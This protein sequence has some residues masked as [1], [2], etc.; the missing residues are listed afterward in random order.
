MADKSQESQ[1]CQSCGYPAQNGHSKTCPTRSDESEKARN[2][3]YELFVNFLVKHG[4]DKMSKEQKVAKIKELNFEEIIQTISR[5]NGRLAF[6]DKKQEWKGKA[7]RVFVGIGGNDKENAS[8]EPPENAENELKLFFEKMQSE[9]NL[10]NLHEW[11]GKA[12]FAIVFS[13]AFENGNGRSARNIYYLLCEDGT[14]PQN[15]ANRRVGEVED[16]TNRIG[17]NAMTRLFDEK[18]IACN[19]RLKVMEEYSATTSDDDWPISGNMAYLKFLAAREVLRQEGQDVTNV[20]SINIQKLNTKQ[21][22]AYDEI[23]KNLRKEWFWKI[24]EV[25]DI[26]KKTVLESLDHILPEHDLS[27]KNER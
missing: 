19:G 16:I 7:A 2:E 24:I 6:R 9:I 12:Y 8:L 27:E 26:Y 3:G 15:L 20:K 4:I 21:K 17:L 11:A 1:V 18:G 14:P 10:E 22:T 25:T 5:I 13:H 23:Y